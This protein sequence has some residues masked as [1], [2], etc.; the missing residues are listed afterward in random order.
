MTLLTGATGL[1]GRYLLAD[2]SRSRLPV[3]VIVRSSRFRSANERIESVF[4]GLERRFGRSFVRPVVLEG[5]LTQAHLG[6]SRDQQDWVAR[7]CGRV[8]HS[9][10]SLSFK[11]AVEHSDGEPYRTNVEG[12]ERLLKFCSEAGIRE[13]HY[14]STAYVCGLRTGHVREDERFVGQTFANDYEKSKVTAENLLAESSEVHSLT[15]YRPSIVIDEDSGSSLSDKSLYNTFSTYLML[16]KKFGLPERGEWLKLL[17]LSGHERKNVV[18]ADWVA[19]MIIQILR[20]PTLHNRTYH[21]T[22]QAGISVADIDQGFRD[23]VKA[24]GIEPLPKHIELST[25]AM[26][27]LAKPFV[28]VFANYFRDDPVFDQANIDDARKVCGE[29]TCPE[30]T[31]DDIQA[32]SRDQMNARASI[33]NDAVE[34]TAVRIPFHGLATWAH[35]AHQPSVGLIASGPRGGDWTIASSTDRATSI[36]VGGAEHCPIRLYAQSATWTR[37]IEQEV[38]IETAIE[39]GRPCD[40]VGCDH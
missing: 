22:S 8:L 1:I 30:V 17:G 6:L 35:I 24:S 19:R 33:A 25:E 38:S 36:H 29:S 12:T 10:A 14:V 20:H 7:N 4:V 16:A 23:V 11:P 2:F 26:S 9:A 3:A 18:R 5:D 31:T 40:R 34:S 21:L 37:L 13:W 15:V 32:L 39:Q 27:R 28:E